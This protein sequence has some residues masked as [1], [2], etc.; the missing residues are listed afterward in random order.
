MNNG[1]T[2]T[3]TST[4]NVGTII[5]D[6]VLRPLLSDDPTTY[7]VGQKV[8]IAYHVIAGLTNLAW[9]RISGTNDWL[10]EE[11]VKPAPSLFEKIRVE[12]ENNG[13]VGSTHSL[14]DYNSI[15]ESDIKEKSAKEL[16]TELAKEVAAMRGILPKNKKTTS[17]NNVKPLT[18]NNKGIYGMNKS[19]LRTV[20]NSL[21]PGQTIGVKFASEDGTFEFKG[22]T[23]RSGDYTLTMV[24]NGRG[25]GASRIMDLADSSRHHVLLGT[26]NSDWIQN[27]TVNGETHGSSVA[28]FGLTSGGRDV[29]NAA[30]LKETFKTIKSYTDA[31][32]CTLRLESTVK[33]LSGDFKIMGSR[34]MRG[35]GGQIVLTLQKK[36]SDSLAENPVVEVW[37]GRHSGV[38]TRAEI[39]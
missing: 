5:R 3:P 34:S 9:F 37:S 21:T 30:L 39:L 2:D 12:K 32:G 31:S 26:P 1:S 24:K 14:I 22:R 33:A 13:F 23:F 27:L 20:I 7:T 4:S 15:S 25:K 6:A 18:T 28:S 10:S 36:V 8:E 38:I 17:N 16:L 19:E 35:R 11:Q 29:Q